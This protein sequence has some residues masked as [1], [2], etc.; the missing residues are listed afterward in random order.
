MKLGELI[1]VV[2]SAFKVEEKTV[3]LYARTIREAGLLTTGARGVNAPDM[4]PRDLARIAIAFLGADGPSKAVEAVTQLG[5]VTV[6]KTMNTGTVP[7]FA[8]SDLAESLE[9]TLAEFFCGRGSV[10]SMKQLEISREL[11]LAKM[12][13]QAGE[14]CFDGTAEEVEAT[15]LGGVGM[16]TVGR[17]NASALM[18]ITVAY[19]KEV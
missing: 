5:A 4:Q 13:F 7:D 11:K 14:V 8:E 3:K 15:I 18:E 10:V 9:D 19:M 12:S 16:Q 6:N 1:K 17:I 2:A